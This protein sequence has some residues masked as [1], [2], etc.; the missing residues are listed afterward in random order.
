MSKCFR[1]PLQYTLNPNK[2]LL[3]LDI[4]TF[5][6]VGIGP[7]SFG[8]WRERKKDLT[9]IKNTLFQ[10][11]SL[12]EDSLFR[13]SEIRNGYISH[14]TASSGLILP[15][16]AFIHRPMEC[17]RPNLQVKACLSDWPTA[18]LSGLNMHTWTRTKPSPH[19][20]IPRRLMK[21]STPALVA[22]T[23][24]TWGHSHD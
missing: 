18:G 2:A 13:Q 21:C 20:S 3:L 4:K 12:Q 6:D 24:S 19:G 1:Q 10:W 15:S 16:I 22:H 23:R 14:F 8:C 9:F 11:C 5:R 7:F 17:L